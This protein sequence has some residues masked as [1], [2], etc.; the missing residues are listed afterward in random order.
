LSPS[1]SISAPSFR[2]ASTRSIVGC[3]SCSPFTNTTSAFDRITASDGAGSKVWLFVPSG[4]T[5][6]RLIRVPPTFRVIELI[7]ATVVTTFS[8]PLPVSN[9]S[10]QPSDDAGGVGV[11][12]WAPASFGMGEDSAAIASPRTD[13]RLGLNDIWSTPMG[14]ARR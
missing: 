7:G 11:A 12:S 3:S 8:S 5:P 6:A 10:D 1:E 13:R 9:E 4:T 14:R 2:F